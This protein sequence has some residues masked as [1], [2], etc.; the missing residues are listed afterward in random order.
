MLYEIQKSMKKSKKTFP[1]VLDL[2]RFFF[3]K[4]K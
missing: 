1:F 2:N 4:Q 3:Q